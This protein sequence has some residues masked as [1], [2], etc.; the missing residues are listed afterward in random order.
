MSFCKFRTA[1]YEF[2][3]LQVNFDDARHLVESG[4]LGVRIDVKIHT[5]QQLLDVSTA[6]YRIRELGESS[7][8][9][10]QKN[11]HTEFT[12]PIVRRTD[13]QQLLRRSEEHTSELQSLRHLVCRL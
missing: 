11:G 10:E 13:V 3:I 1:R 6:N 8:A 2:S 5:S 12:D 7:F 4:F 9:V